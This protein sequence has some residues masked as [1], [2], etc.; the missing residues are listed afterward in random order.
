MSGDLGSSVYVTNI[1]SNTW[2]VGYIIESQVCDQGRLFEQEG[3]RLPNATS[4]TQ[5]SN[6]GIV[7]CKQG[8]IQCI[9]NVFLP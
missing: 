1:S 6:F 7:L 4:G 9:T 2:G 5:E 3:Q 8:S